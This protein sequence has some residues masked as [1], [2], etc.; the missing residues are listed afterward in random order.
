MFRDKDKDEDLPNRPRGVG[1]SISRPT[2]MQF[3]FLTANY[4][5]TALGLS[6]FILITQSP[7]KSQR[8]LE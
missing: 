6:G 2:C 5:S 3:L 1:A 8:W 4:G 7:P